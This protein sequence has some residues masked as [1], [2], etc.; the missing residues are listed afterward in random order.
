MKF[1][2]TITKFLKT[3]LAALMIF[4]SLNF[5]GME[6]HAAT[7][8]YQAKSSL[9]KAF[10]VNGIWGKSS[11]SVYQIKLDGTNAF[12]LDL[13]LSMTGNIYLDR[14]EISGVKLLE[15][16]KKAVIFAD[17]AASG[18]YSSNYKEMAYWI[19]QTLIWGY[20][21]GYISSSMDLGI[22]PGTS[23]G[24]SPL[25]IQIGNV[26]RA[27]GMSGYINDDIGETLNEI[28]N[29]STSGYTFYMYRYK[30]GYQRL[31]TTESGY[32]PT[33]NS[34]E[35][36]SRKD[37]SI[38]DK[39]TLNINKTDDTTNKGLSGV[40]FDIYKD[41]VKAGTVT[42]DSDGKA[43][44]LF[45]KA[46][47]ATSDT[48]TKTYCTNYY[49]LSP[50]NQA[51]V[52]AVDY[53]SKADAQAA[54]D[55]AALA[56][57][58]A[59]VQKYLDEK[60][61]YKAVETET[62]YAYYLNPDKVTHTSSY[63]SGDGTGSVTMNITNARQTGNVTITKLDT[64]TG[65]TVAGA[66]YGLYA[67]SA[68]VHPDGHTGTLFA[69]DALVA[70]F[71]ATDTNGK[72]TLKN[73]YLGEYYVK[74]ITAPDKYVLSADRYNVDLTYDGQTLSVT[75]ASTDVK[76]KVQRG[77]IT[78]VKT[79]DG[80]NKG[81]T[82]AIFELYAKNDIVHPDG[83]TGVIYAAGTKIATF[84]ATNDSGKTTIT[85]L[86]LGDYYVKELN[87]ANGYVLNKGTHT[88]KLAYAGQNVEITS[89]SSDIS[90][91]RQE[92]K[93]TITKID[94]ETENAL[95]GAIYGLYARND[96][97][98]PD[99]K[100][101]VVYSK[102]T[103][104]SKF[105]STNES[106]KSYLD[107]LYLGNYYIKEINTPDGYVLNDKEYDVSLVYAGQNIAV[108][109]TASTVTDVVQ[110]NEITIIKKDSETGTTAQGDATLQGATYGLY[111]KE[112]IIHADETTGV[113]KYDAVKDS[114]HEIVLAHGSDLNVLDTKATAG[115][116]IATAKTDKDGKITFS[117][118]Y[119]GK[120]FI[121]EIEPSEGYLLDETQHDFDL[122][123]TGQNDAVNSYSKDVFETVMKQGFEL[124]KVSGDGDSEESEILKDVEFTVKLASEVE[125]VGWKE[126]RIYDILTTDERGH[127]VSIELPYGTY[128]VKETKSPV[129]YLPSKDI[130]VVIDKDSR[131]PQTWRVVNNKPFEAIIKI[132][133]EDIDTGKTVLKAGTEFKIY[134]LDTKEYV[135][136]WAWNPLPHYVDSW[137]TDKTGTLMLNEALPVGDY[138]LEE[139]TAPSGYVQGKPVTFRVTTNTDYEILDDGMTAVITVTMENKPVYGYISIQK[140]GETLVST[141]T[142]EDGN[143]TFIYEDNGIPYAK[144]NIEAAEDIYTQD[145]QGTLIYSKGQI[146][147]QVE[148]SY[149]HGDTKLLPLGKYKVYELE[150]NYGFV[151]NSEAQYAEL[152]YEGQNVEFVYRDTEFYNERQKVELDITK[153]DADTNTPLQGAVY[154]LYSLSNIDGYVELVPVFISDPLVKENQ[155]LATAT[156]D[157]N[158]KVNFNIDLPIGYEFMIKEVQAPKG[159]ASSDE[160]FVFSTHIDDM[161]QEKL[162]VYHTF[163]NEITKVSISKKDITNDG[164]IAGAFLVVYNKEDNTILDTWTSGSDGYNEDGTIKPHLIKGLEVGK[165]Y[166]LEEIIAPYGYAYAN[167]IEFTVSD[168][169]EIQTVEMKDELVL[170]Q[171]KWK[172][173][174]EIFNEVVNGT[175]EYGETLLPTWNMSNLKGAEITIYAA[176]DITIGNHTYFKADEAIETLV[177][178]DED[179]LSKELYVGRYY[180]M[181]TKVPEGYIL[182][183]TK[184]YF[185]VENNMINELQTIESSLLNERGTFTIDMIKVLEEQEIFKNTDAYKDII[186]GIHARED[187]NYYTGELAIPAG[188]L[189][190]ISEIDD[191]GKLVNNFDLPF[192]K[193]YIKE[194]ATNSQYVLNDTEYDFEVS[195][196]GENISHYT[197]KIDEDGIIDNE[198]ARGEIKVIKKDSDDDTKVL[199]GVLFEISINEDMSEPFATVETDE[200]GVA[201]FSELELGTYYIRE[202]KQVDGY[203][204]NETI[205][206]VEVTADGD[207]LEI[208]CVNT[209]TEMFFSKQD[210]TNS[211]ELPGAHIVIKDKETGEI[212]DEWVSTEEPHIIKYLVEGKE[213]I[214]IE[215]QA[216]KGYQIAEQITFVAKDGTTITMHDKLIPET[217][218]TGDDSNIV[219]W[220]GLSISSAMLLGIMMLL[221]KKDQKQM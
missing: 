195:Y 26:M 99:G 29:I 153:V 147:D 5:T 55:A 79:D 130:T 92:G 135:G 173:T 100:T 96:I 44:Y 137:K 80:T 148:I 206:K 114:I 178:G 32:R 47:S 15:Q 160:E 34:D 120:Y 91:H 110:R 200:N 128:T 156:S 68:I 77:N 27:A 33:Y 221:K 107:G 67:R 145:N 219:L 161:K 192:G 69:K 84:P 37:Y 30:N 62:K 11:A 72:A 133:K 121:K 179:V 191:C 51:A 181:E 113:V 149:G 118:L 13:G 204:I 18:N 93:I 198:L 10:S 166:Y 43:S 102:D 122:S 95:D 188:S 189:I 142:D 208:T 103:L 82:G 150:T 183:T 20:Q 144:F 136:Y 106:G 73:L 24:E 2:K 14:V 97:I 87:A 158:G 159:Y 154:E 52:G 40:K 53:A 108:T 214:M 22:Q 16:V 85:N 168:T 112:D 35:V 60:H 151:L 75:S 115:T 146:V 19:S 94:E 193:Y 170:G 176:E 28:N 217:P 180:Y 196:K 209:P 54:A 58:K 163:K 129:D 169:G 174:G 42:T 165:T 213:Y 141:E 203:V 6:V 31:I 111:V 162:T 197:I 81:L 216:P 134:N 171:L 4:T 89:V 38:T 71:P 104:I 207:S 76:D 63:A 9:V 74:E 21:E 167:E 70:K 205:Y 138:R 36:Q 157:E 59:K 48:I 78:V 23:F 127:A 1:K 98:H 190:A 105:P 175:T 220:S 49:Q 64:E 124:I 8:S 194:L 46:Y 152:E 45:E 184:H 7:G 123:Y 83:K 41:D 57:A 140:D 155:L 17:R 199:T 187:I 56:N 201:L 125:K 172:K 186:F 65:K 61:T 212:I 202:A 66:V 143:I 88:V 25:V 90:N 218:K 131:L 109:D 132:V 116:L 117:H 12:C 50:K 39:V 211:K 215:T 126:A 86:Y 182:D 210:I 139:V 101:G 3:M 185:T 119:N 164:E 177:S